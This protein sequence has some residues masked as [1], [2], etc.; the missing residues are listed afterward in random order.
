LNSCAHC[1]EPI[2]DEAFASYIEEA[3]FVAPGE[4]LIGPPSV[5]LY[6]HERC[7]GDWTVPEGHF[8]A[9]ALPDVRTRET[10]CHVEAGKQKLSLRRDGDGWAINDLDPGS[11]LG[12]TFLSG[13]RFR[14]RDGREIPRIMSMKEVEDFLDIDYSTD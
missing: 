11:T 14:L 4:S 6:V 2:G 13:N 5:T 10:R 7:R 9:A 8:L 1:H 3:H 12:L